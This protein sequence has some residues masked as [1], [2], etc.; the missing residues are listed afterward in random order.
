MGRSVDDHVHAVAEAVRAAAARRA[1]DAALDQA[2]RDVRGGRLARSVRAQR[3]VPGFDNSQMD[4]FAV[5]AADLV[6]ADLEPVRLATVAHVVAG[7][8]SPARLARGTAA[9]IMTG[10]PLPPGADAVVPVERT[11]SRDFG[12]V[13]GGATVEFASS[14]DPGTFVRRRGTDVRLGDVLL[15]AGAPLHPAAV[16][17]LVAAGVDRVQ[18]VPPLRIAFVGTGSELV[19][20]D[21]P[22]SNTAALLA[23]A[24][25][26]G[27]HGESYLVEDDPAALAA[28]L[29]RLATD[30]DLVVT[31]GGVSAGTREVVRQCLEGTPGAWFGHVDVQPGGPQGLAEITSAGRTVPVVCLPGNPVSV[32]VSFELFLRPPL[33]ESA[34]LVPWRR[35]GTAPLAEALE[36]PAGRLQIRRGH[37]DADG[38]VSLV[39]GPGSHLVAAYARANLLVLVPEAVTSMSVGDTVEWWRIA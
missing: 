22:D 35:S 13:D 16:G 27:V 21:V 5:A 20:G 24:H 39:G 34:G 25:D 3:D 6:L 32:L 11:A 19:S 29:D 31:T 30:H 23:H 4:G 10:A 8:L 28:L 37:L 9:P 17:A 38:R 1:Q 33:A 36:S 14:V 12:P 15:D 2:L 7:G 26:L 18:V